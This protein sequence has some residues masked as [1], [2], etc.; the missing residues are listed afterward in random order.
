MR[1][2]NRGRQGGQGLGE[3]RPE[4]RRGTPEAWA[5]K[6]GKKEIRD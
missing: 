5:A 6:T 3:S 2:G 4:K 1:V